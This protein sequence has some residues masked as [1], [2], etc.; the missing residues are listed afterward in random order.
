MRRRLIDALEDAIWAEGL[1]A[2]LRKT[3]GSGAELYC[4]GLIR[5]HARSDPQ[6]ERLQDVRRALRWV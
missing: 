2:E 4:D 6:W 5:T 1:A 3:H